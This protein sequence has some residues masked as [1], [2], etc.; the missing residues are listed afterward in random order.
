M[1]FYFSVVV[2]SFM[3]N[4]HSTTTSLSSGLDNRSIKL[5]EEQTNLS[6]S[7]IREQYVKFKGVTSGG[8]T[9]TRDIFSQI[10]HKCYPRTYKVNNPDYLRG[11]QVTI[12]PCNQC[13]V[14]N[15][16]CYHLKKNQP[17]NNSNYVRQ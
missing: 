8:E 13:D 15:Q 2:Q 9:I 12:Q 16:K 4:H 6:Q 14:F 11:D 17:I 7:E 3:G 10:M 5:L 1:C